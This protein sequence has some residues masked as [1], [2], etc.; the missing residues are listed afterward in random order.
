MDIHLVHECSGWPDG[1]A[2]LAKLFQS[3]A[4]SGQLICGLALLMMLA[5]SHAYLEA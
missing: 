5:G 1:P 3:W 2:G 4:V